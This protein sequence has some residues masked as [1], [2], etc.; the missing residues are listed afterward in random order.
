MLLTPPQ[1]SLPGQLGCLDRVIRFVDKHAQH[2][3][4]KDTCQQAVSDKI[5]DHAPS[6]LSNCSGSNDLKIVSKSQATCSI[7]VSSGNLFSL[8]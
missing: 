7:S 5:K 1:Q 4:Y 6:Q 8:L 2:V 3:D